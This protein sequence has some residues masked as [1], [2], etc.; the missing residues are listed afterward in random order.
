M[1]IIFVWIILLSLTACAGQQKEQQE[2]K[3]AIKT[4]TDTPKGA[5]EVKKEYDDFA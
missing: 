1:R 4:E 3:K 5:W 2:E